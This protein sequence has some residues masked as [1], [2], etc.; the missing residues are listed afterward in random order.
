MI[1][2]AR[3]FAMKW[4]A[5]QQYGDQP[6]LYHL[7]Q[8]AQ[9]LHKYGET[10]QAIAYLHDVVEDTS[11]S[12]DELRNEFG[13]LI[14]ACVSICTD[15]PG[16]TRKERKSLT[17]QKMATVEG[18]LELALI[19]K[20]ADRLANMKSCIKNNHQRLLETY[21]Q[22]Y[23][24]FRAGAYRPQICDDIWQEITAL[25][26]SLPPAAPSA[27]T[28][29]AS[30]IPQSPPHNHVFSTAPAASFAFQEEPEPAF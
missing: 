14:A 13:Q 2:R 20:A 17:Y 18:E 22:E 11:V 15:E 6:Y 5:D 25:T 7:Q 3:Q 29:T 16:A 12:I 23:A 24:A 10:A 19:V 9:I 26:F 4:H 8:V 21:R 30:P 27:P 28:L 1:E